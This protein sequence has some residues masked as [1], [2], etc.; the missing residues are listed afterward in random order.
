MSFM[1]KA[2]VFSIGPHPE[3]LAGHIAWKWSFQTYWKLEGFT[4]CP[5]DNA[6][7]G[8]LVHV[9]SQTYT[10]LNNYFWYIS[11]VPMWDFSSKIFKDLRFFKDLER[12]FKNLGK[13][14]EVQWS[15]VIFVFPWHIIPGKLCT[16]LMKKISTGTET[17]RVFRAERDAAAVVATKA[18]EEVATTAARVKVIVEMVSPSQE[19]NLTFPWFMVLHP[20]CG[21]V[22][23]IERSSSKSQWRDPRQQG[24]PLWTDGQVQHMVPWDVSTRQKWT[25][26][27]W[28]GRPFR[29]KTRRMWGRGYLWRREERFERGCFEVLI[30]I[31]ILGK[32]HRIFSKHLKNEEKSF[33]L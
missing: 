10:H 9:C 5:Q 11:N 1:V 23:F 3:D 6:L 19:T 17:L 13:V 22:Y 15:S 20:D 24:P 32:K 28:Q 26:Q 30:K 31:K 2:L 14:N 29:Y 33:L 25:R 27:H 7:P 12:T 4:L 16:L 21:R 18:T 8:R